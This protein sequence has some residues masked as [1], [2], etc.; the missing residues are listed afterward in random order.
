MSNH[1]PCE[2]CKWYCGNNDCW[3]VQYQ[4]HHSKIYEE[5]QLEG[6]RDMCDALIDELR[7]ES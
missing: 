2:A 7:G 4:Q 3:V 1:H 5:G 6:K